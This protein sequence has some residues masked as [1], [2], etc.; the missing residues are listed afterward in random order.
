MDFIVRFMIKYKFYFKIE[1]IYYRN[2]VI[3]VITI[4]IKVIELVKLLLSA[5]LTAE[6]ACVEEYSV[7]LIAFTILYTSHI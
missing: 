4:I 5:L 7:L 6:L 2:L 1:I 3:I